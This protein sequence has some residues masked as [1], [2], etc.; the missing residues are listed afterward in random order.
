LF[1]ELQDRM[2][3]LPGVRSMSAVT[4]LPLSNSSNSSYITFDGRP[5]PGPGMEIPG[6]NRLIVMA[7]Y[8]E[9]LGMRIREGRSFTRQDRQGADPVAIVN[10]AMAKRYWPGESPIGRRIKRGTP[11][12]PFP[13]MTVVGV[14]ADIKQISLTAGANPTVFLPY[15]QSA[16]PG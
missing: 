8:F 13:W 12:A 2:A 1:E 9:T 6:A 14:V 16:E 11:N 10:E 5:A 15:L 3:A 7:G 4:N